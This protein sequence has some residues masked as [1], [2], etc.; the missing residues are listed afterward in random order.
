MT[1]LVP[2]ELATERAI[3]ARLVLELL[4]NVKRHYFP[5]GEFLDAVELALV[6]VYVFLAQ[7]DRRPCTVTYLS[8]KIG[9]SRATVRRRTAHLVELGY[10]ESSSRSYLMGR[11]FAKPPGGRRIVQ[12]H[13]AAINSAARKLAKLA[14][15]QT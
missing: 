7:Q 14:A 2:I 9:L 5:K 3:V 13:I 12:A 10:V 6:G 1:T 8:R 4:H 15:N 11:G